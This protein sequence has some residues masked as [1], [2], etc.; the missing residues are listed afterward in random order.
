MISLRLIT[1]TIY[2]FNIL[3]KSDS[4]HLTYQKDMLPVLNFQIIVFI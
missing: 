3:Q 1:Q 2:I 4:L